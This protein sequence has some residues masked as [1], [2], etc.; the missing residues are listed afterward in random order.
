[1]TTD[2]FPL[3][4]SQ[5]GSVFI[6]ELLPSLFNEGCHELLTFSGY[7]SPTLIFSE[8]RVAQTL[9]LFCKSVFVLFIFG[10]CLYL[11]D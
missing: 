4:I 10:H 8:V 9:V 3:A 6:H 5:S 7:L 2:M 11:F 1:M